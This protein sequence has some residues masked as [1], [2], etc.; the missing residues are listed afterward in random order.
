M[1][2]SPTSDTAMTLEQARAVLW[3]RNNHRPMG[4]LLDEGYLNEA[5]L[6]WAAEK[7]FDPQIKQAA[8]VL[9]GSLRAAIAPPAPASIP[10]PALETGTAITT[11]KTG[12]TLEQARATR[13][14]FSNFKNQPMGELVDAHQLTLKDLVYA[15]ENAWNERVRQAAIALLAVRLDQAVEEPASS[16][17]PLKVVSGG[18]S[19]SESRRLAWTLLQGILLGAGAV[20]WALLH[21]TRFHQKSATIRYRTF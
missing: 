13:W 14:P 20:L 12:I 3:L 4:E 17:G 2:L 7:A 5:R 1:S 11:I 16:A 8:G 18:Q 19:Y 10:A 9:L 21:H 6:R 15:I